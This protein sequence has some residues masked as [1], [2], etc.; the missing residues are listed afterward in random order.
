M[1]SSRYAY[2]VCECRE[3]AA[4]L[5]ELRE[6]LRAPSSCDVDVLPFLYEH[7]RIAHRG[8]ILNIVMKF[9]MKF[10]NSSRKEII[11]SVDINFLLE[12]RVT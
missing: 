2:F 5:K 1:L 12:R 7:H 11:Q 9:Q 8:K 6:E 10:K 4:S 3:R